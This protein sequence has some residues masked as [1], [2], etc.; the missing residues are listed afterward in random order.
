MGEEPAQEN[1]DNWWETPGGP[2]AD[3][4]KAE[5]EAAIDAETKLEQDAQKWATEG[6]MFDDLVVGS[7]VRS[8]SSSNPWVYYESGIICARELSGDLKKNSSGEKIINLREW[9]RLSRQQR[10]ALRHQNIRRDEWEKL[11]WT[12]HMCYLFTRAWEIGRLK[13]HYTRE[14]DFDEIE[15]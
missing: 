10:I 3:Q 2:S 13:S 8:V 14:K 7:V 5:R 11:P 4:R 1:Y 12:G 15:R 6:Y 9:D